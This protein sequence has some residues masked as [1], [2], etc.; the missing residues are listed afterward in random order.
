MNRREFSSITALASVSLAFPKT[1]AWFHK[2]SRRI[3]GALSQL[4]TR[5]EVLKTSG[6][7]RRM[8][9]RGTR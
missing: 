2:S 3:V 5:V 4:T 6:T 1:D 9:A 8:G 7:T